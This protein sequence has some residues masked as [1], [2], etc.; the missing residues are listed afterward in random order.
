MLSI[1]KP[2]LND[3]IIPSRTSIE[4]RENFVSNYQ[5]PN[6]RQKA[7]RCKTCSAKSNIHST[8]LFKS[9]KINQVNKTKSP[10]AS[11]RTKDYNHK[12]T[13]NGKT[14]YLST[15]PVSLTRH[16]PWYCYRVLAGHLGWV[17][18]IAVDHTNTWFCTGSSDRTIKVWN[19]ASGELKLTLT[20]HLEQVTGLA[21]S[22]RHPYMFSC[23]LDKTVKCWDLE[24]N[25][26]IRSYHGHLSGIYC[27]ALHPALDLVLSGGRD[28]VCRVWDMRTK[29]QIHC[30]T[31]HDNTLG[32]ILTQAI[33]P[34][35]ITGSYDST[36]RLWDLR[37]GA[38]RKT[39]T[40]HKKGVRALVAL[41]EDSTFYSASADNIKKFKLP[42]GTFLHNMVQQ[43]HCIVNTLAI[44]KNGVL[45]SGGD[46]GNVWF[47]DINTGSCFDQQ[48][49]LVQP[50]SLDSEAG[51]FASC[52]DMTG[53]RLITCE[54]DK[55][56]KMWKEEDSEL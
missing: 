43:H 40:F 7:S 35:V 15:S 48:Q 3:E 9:E 10:D 23:G 26:V 18:S 2:N 42:E 33:D 28:S 54:A 29:V 53:S 4:T 22:Q 19:V 52:F 44:N 31:G 49:T 36:I 13:L 51:I 17:R 25:K 41:P 11:L 8:V 20:G 12:K 14:N 56:I 47:W 27:L 38:T 55:T 30:L 6:V 37:M 46:N 45:V 16:V 32:S 1:Q 21:V 50:G 34:Q 5:V 39:L 24:Y